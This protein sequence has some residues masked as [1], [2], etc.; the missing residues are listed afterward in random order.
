MILVDTSI[1]IEILN[2][3]AG[4]RLPDEDVLQWATC[5]P[6]LQEVLQ[7]SGTHPAGAQ[8][9]EYMLA[10]PRL[11]DPVTLDTFLAAADI[12]RQ[13]RIRGYTIRSSMDCLIGAIAIQNNTPVL[14]RDRDFDQI[15][16]FTP[17]HAIRSM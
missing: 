2:G 10:L 16:R 1:W 13:G 12:Y 5:G 9:R 15:A 14:H 6:V 17:L 4:K 11:S 7:G 3:S 8:F